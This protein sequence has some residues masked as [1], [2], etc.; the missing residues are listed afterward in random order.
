MAGRPDG[1]I[2]GD[3]YMPLWERSSCDS[4]RSPSN[5]GIYLGA[6]DDCSINA[7]YFYYDSRLPIKEHFVNDFKGNGP[8]DKWEINV[9]GTS[10][11]VIIRFLKK[12]HGL[13]KQM[14][15]VWESFMWLEW[16]RQ[17]SV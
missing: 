11:K 12:V 16:G 1:W 14:K 5:S 15:G 8:L 4:N 6:Q 10:Y 13:E 9:N 7:S 2:N 3:T 17:I